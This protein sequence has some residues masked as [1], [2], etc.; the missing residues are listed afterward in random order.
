MAVPVAAPVEMLAPDMTPVSGNPGFAA[1]LW[2]N[3]A[4]MF[5]ARAS[6]E[7]QR[8]VVSTPACL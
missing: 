7:W 1:M 5:A 8:R 6:Y 4:S 3:A 2:L